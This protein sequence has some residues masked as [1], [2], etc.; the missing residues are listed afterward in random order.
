M[1]RNNSI[2]CALLYV[3]YDL[4][5][6]V[7]ITHAVY[8]FAPPLSERS[9]EQSAD[10]ITQLD[11]HGLVLCLWR[12]AGGTATTHKTQLL[13]RCD[14]PEHQNNTCFLVACRWNSLQ[15]VLNLNHTALQQ[16]LAKD[17]RLL[18]PDSKTLA[19]NHAA[20]L[21]TLNIAPTTLNRWV[22]A[23]PMLMLVPAVQLQQRLD[24]LSAVMAQ[25]GLQLI[26][27]A[28]AA[29]DA[30]AAAAAAAALGDSVAS[31]P[32]SISSNGSSS[33]NSGGSGI[34]WTCAARNPLQLLAYV[35]KDPRV[36]L[37]SVR[38]LP[39]KVWQV[40]KELGC[41][42]KAAAWLAL[43]HP[44]YLAMEPGLASVWMDDVR[45]VAGVTLQ[46]A[47]RLSACPQVRVGRESEGRGFCKD[48][49]ASDASFGRAGRDPRGCDRSLR[50]WGV[51]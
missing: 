22:F 34:A 13:N 12:P 26:A 41:G 47:K 9:A 45:H 27:A 39:Q 50:S 43:Q 44:S 17:P 48:H 2:P 20:I 24:K 33:R 7:T 28:A 1:L 42:V 8:G 14:R 11:M 25:E 19:A 16:L 23:A 29:S 46:H 30:P 35:S 3:M 4:A 6:S 37:L 40:S 36:L 21:Q 31:E 18:M 5:D 15:S 49:V 32:C 51:E 38:E 10:N